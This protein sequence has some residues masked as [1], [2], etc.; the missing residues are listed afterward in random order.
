MLSHLTDD[1]KQWL[2]LETM[3]AVNDKIPD[4]ICMMPKCDEKATGNMFFFSVSTRF[5]SSLCLCGRCYQMIRDA[6]VAEATV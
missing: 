5:S 2:L 4:I 3:K 6:Q 1:E